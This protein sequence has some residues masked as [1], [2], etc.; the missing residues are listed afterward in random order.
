MVFQSAGFV[1]FL[2]NTSESIDMQRE[3]V[4]SMREH[5]ISGLIVSPARAT[6]AA[7]FKPLVAAG[8]PVVFDR[9]LTADI[10]PARLSET[11]DETL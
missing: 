8:I 4:A 9:C 2:S 1:Q 10:M 6:Y 5:G 3:V 7:D 11:T